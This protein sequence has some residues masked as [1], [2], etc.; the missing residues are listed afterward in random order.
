[1]YD[2]WS[3]MMDV[4]VAVDLEERGTMEPIESFLV[5]SSFTFYIHTTPPHPKFHHVT[6]VRLGTEQGTSPSKCL[7]NKQTPEAQ[8]SAYIKHHA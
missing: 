5:G 3:A 4:A 7:K 6:R 2:P 1:M 8:R